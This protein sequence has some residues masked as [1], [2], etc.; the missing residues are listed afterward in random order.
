ML[1]RTNYLQ[2][3]TAANEILCAS[4]GLADKKA[5]FLLLAISSTNDSI[6]EI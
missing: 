6:D 2:G 4:Q 5:S 3:A 1:G